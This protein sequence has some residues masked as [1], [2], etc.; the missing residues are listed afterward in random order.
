MTDLAANTVARGRRQVRPH[1]RPGIGGPLPFRCG[2]NSRRR[3]CRGGTI[4]HMRQRNRLHGGL[5]GA[6]TRAFLLVLGAAALAGCSVK[7]NFGSA[8]EACDR[9]HEQV[10]AGQYGAVYESTSRGFQASTDRERLVGFLGR[11]GRKMGK[12]GQATVTFGGYQATTSGTFV[13]TTAARTCA[14][15]RLSER[16][17]W[18]M[19]GGKAKLL[20]YN[21]DSPLLLTD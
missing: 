15:G 3:H 1:R 13:T 6:C 12:C 19:D 4:T 7:A 11:V 16:F 21:A 20:R 5:F 2:G 9:F 18:V 17:M 14:N 8:K 10:D